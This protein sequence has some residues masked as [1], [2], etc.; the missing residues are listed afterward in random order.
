MDISVYYQIL[1]IGIQYEKGRKKG[2][3]WRL[4]ERK[5]L[6]EE[7]KFWRLMLEYISDELGGIDCSTQVFEELE[8]ICKRYKFPNYERIITKKCEIIGSEIIFV[9]Q[10]EQEK[11]IREIMKI[12]LEDMIH[13]LTCL[14]GKE[15]F[16][17][18]L[19]ILHNFPKAMHGKNV[20]CNHPNLVSYKDA[21]QYAE[22]CLCTQTLR[23]RYGKLFKGDVNVKELV[24]E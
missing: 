14:N 3:Y 18:L 21:L 9:G 2:S 12:L 24:D 1:D 6:R 8:S 11:S 17:Q 15:E 10:E 4:G 22:N 13:L 5:C 23:E 20:L 16:F 7:V 19:A